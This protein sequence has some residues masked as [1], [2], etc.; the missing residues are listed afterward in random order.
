MK[1]S[2]ILLFVYN[3]PGHTKKTVEALRKNKL[4]QKSNLFIFSDGA[5]GMK[6][7]KQV[8]EVR[9]YIK[10]ITG[11]KRIEIIERKKN[12]G[13][14]SSIITGVTKIINKYGKVIVLEDDLVT[15]PA[16]LYF[17]NEIL[18]KYKNSQKVFSITGYNYPVRLMKIPNVYPYDIYFST[19]AGSWG[20]ATWKDRWEKS[21]WEIKDYNNFL[22]DKRG[23]KEFNRGGQDMSHMLISQME[24]KVDSWAIRWCYSLYKNNGL[25]VYPTKSY[26]DN[27]G[28]DNTGVHCGKTN[29]YSNKTLNTKIKINFPLK[30]KK[31]K[32]II[33]NFRK[34]YKRSLKNYIKTAIKKV[35]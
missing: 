28:L 34:V 4:A 12:L 2:P 24:G 27:I 20:L 5:K 25:C 32:K 11:F 13:L 9:K 14:A 33:R 1:Y 19:R 21:D 26:V 6:E 7:K 35:F 15:S 30:I 22:S 29:K 8:E 3:R 31:N 23:Q 18:E 17:M 10:S 16:F